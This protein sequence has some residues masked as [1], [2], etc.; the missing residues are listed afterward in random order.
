M[1]DNWFPNTLDNLLSVGN[2]IWDESN[3][4]RQNQ[5]QVSQRPSNSLKTS[6]WIFGFS[7]FLT[8]VALWLVVASIRGGDYSFRRDYFDFYRDMFST[9]PDMV[10]AWLFILFPVFLYHFALACRY[11]YRNPEQLR[12]IFKFPR[13]HK[14]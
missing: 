9:G 7:L 10:Y 6:I 12:V 2:V 13:R 8:P 1:A 14:P 11:Y 4:L 5:T 3:G